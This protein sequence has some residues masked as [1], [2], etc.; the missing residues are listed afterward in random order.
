MELNAFL[1]NKIV[2]NV[3][4]LLTVKFVKQVI[5]WLKANVFSVQN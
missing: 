2:N 1:V 3:K 4:T 5:L